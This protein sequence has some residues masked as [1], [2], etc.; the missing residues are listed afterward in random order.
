MDSMHSLKLAICHTFNR[1]FARTGIRFG[2]MYVHDYDYDYD[3]V[4]HLCSGRDRVFK[5]DSVAGLSESNYAE[6]PQE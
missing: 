4:S 1:I 6:N 2:V 3:L 5:C